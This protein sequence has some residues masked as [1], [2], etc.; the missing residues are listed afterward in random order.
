MEGKQIRIG[1]LLNHSELGIV[2]VIAVG[3]EYIH[4]IYNNETHYE[5][6]NRFSGIP[7]TEESVFKVGFEVVK[8]YDVK[9]IVFKNDEYLI[10][11]IRSNS[12]LWNLRYRHRHLH[13][14]LSL[15]YVESLHQ[16]QNIVFDLT[17][18]E[19]EIKL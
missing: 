13:D 17:G 9:S 11:A 1:N 12:R 2:E 16:L 19:L 7:I 10:V 15:C 6:L 5:T 18:K 4:C 3:K 14:D 8:I